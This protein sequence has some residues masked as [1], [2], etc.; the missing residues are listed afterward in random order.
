[1]VFCL[2]IKLGRRAAGCGAELPAWKRGGLT[3]LWARS[4]APQPWCCTAI[5]AMLPHP[6]LSPATWARHALSSFLGSFQCPCFVW[7]LLAQNWT[8][9]NCFAHHCQASLQKY[10]LLSLLPEEPRPMDLPHA[11]HTGRK[12]NQCS[13]SHIHITSSYWD[14]FIELGLT[15]LPLGCHHRLSAAAP[16]SFE[17]LR[18]TSQQ[19]SWF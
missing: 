4:S 1:M 18:R 12:S 2:R 3:S 5:T 13:Y 7:L 10:A 9:V 19:S 15:L 11:R 6:L 16:F 14:I 17:I 8:K